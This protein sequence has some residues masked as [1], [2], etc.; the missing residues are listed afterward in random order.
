MGGRGEP[1]LTVEARNRGGKKRQ[2]RRWDRVRDRWGL[3]SRWFLLR[4]SGFSALRVDFFTD[5]AYQPA[6][7][8]TDEVYQPFFLRTNLG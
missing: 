7:F 1:L 2:R 6:I 4:S 3:T 5:K 8:L